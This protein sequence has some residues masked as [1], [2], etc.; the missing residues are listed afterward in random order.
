MWVVAYIRTHRQGTRQGMNSSTSKRNH[1]DQECT[2]SYL[3]AVHLP[4]V[5]AHA[6]VCKL[7]LTPPTHCAN[8]GGETN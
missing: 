7:Y 3:I 8:C 5:N 2:N 6:F 4:N 1:H